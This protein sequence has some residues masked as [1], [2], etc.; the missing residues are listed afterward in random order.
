MKIATDKINK[1]LIT[2][3]PNRIEWIMLGIVSFMFYTTMYYTDN[4][5]IFGAAFSLN[6]ELI[7]GESLNL[8]GSMVHP[9]GVLHQW[10]C[11]LWVAPINILHHLL[12]LNLDNP[13]S[14]LWCKLC[15]VFFLVLCLKETLNIAT[16]LGIS[17]N[18]NRW[19]LFFIVSNI[20]VVLPVFHIAQT[21]CIYLLFMLM[22][23]RA[24]LEKKITGFLVCFAV[25]NSFKM[26]SLFMFIPL[27]LLVE[28]RVFYVFR[29]TLIGCS[30]IFLQRIWYRIVGFINGVLFANRSTE[31]I[32]VAIRGV[33]ASADGIGNFYK[34]IADYTLFFKFPA[35]REGYT[36]SLLILL[37]GILCIWCFVQ[38]EYDCEEMKNKCLYASVLSMIIFFVTAS[39]APYWIILL[40]P[41][42]FL[43][44]Y[45]KNKRIRI[46]LLLEKA[47][48]LSLFIVYVMSTFWV[49][50]GAQT[51]EKLFLTKWGLV[52]TD[53]YLM[54]TPNIAGYLSK[55][56]MEEM[57]PIVTAICLASI[58]GFVW[59]NYPSNKYDEQL[60]GDS[61]LKL[62]HEFAIFNICILYGWYIINVLLLSRY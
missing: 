21:D 46:N 25:A 49:Y 2:E 11:E 26:I 45:C 4:F 52:P 22:G 20:L 62:H 3:N 61:L 58:V 14:I 42:L 1:A 12:G 50:G 56:G 5:A 16:I 19:L 51:F 39:P 15:I 31:S 47:F 32:D 29:N 37:F 7:K 57:M 10:I 18:Y 13:I 54:G 36:A 28:K 38:K 6:E 27:V 34:K 17:K 33:E 40:Y 55:I 35:I 53:H 8:L 44:V 24:L 43:L 41:F 59:I 60:S 48:S 9:Y 23:F 30:I